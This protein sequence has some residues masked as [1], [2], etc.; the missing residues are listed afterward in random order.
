MILTGFIPHTLRQNKM[1]T[2]SEK[3]HDLIMANNKWRLEMW[4]LRL[5]VDT[6]K[7]ASELCKVIMNRQLELEEKALEDTSH[8]TTKGEDA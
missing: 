1:K 7:P 4:A 5:H 2:D 6:T 8:P 3:L